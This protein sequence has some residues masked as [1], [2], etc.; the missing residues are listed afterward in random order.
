MRHKQN[1]PPH[2]PEFSTTPRSFPGVVG[3][4]ALSEKGPF[5]TS[6]SQASGEGTPPMI[7]STKGICLPLMSAGR[8][9]IVMSTE[10]RSISSEEQRTHQNRVLYIETNYS[11]VQP[12]SPGTRR[13]IVPSFFV[14]GCAHCLYTEGPQGSNPSATKWA[15]D[16]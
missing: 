16:G 6:R 12:Q 5:G 11:P 4:G 2:I 8:A 13:T 1:N 9:Y 7:L 14:M 3:G 15:V 10:C